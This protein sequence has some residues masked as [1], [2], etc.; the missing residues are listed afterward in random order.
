[1]LHSYLCR[2]FVNGSFAFAQ[3]RICSVFKSFPGYLP[4]HHHLQPQFLLTWT[5]TVGFLTHGSWCSISVQLQC[6]TVR[7]PVKFCCTH[8]LRH[9]FHK[10]VRYT[11][12]GRLGLEVHGS[13]SIFYRVHQPITIRS[14]TVKHH[15]SIPVFC[16]LG[17]RYLVLVPLQVFIPPEKKPSSQCNN[18]APS[19]PAG[20]ERNHKLCVFEGGIVPLGVSHSAVLSLQTCWLCQSRAAAAEE[21]SLFLQDEMRACRGRGGRER[22]ST[23]MQYH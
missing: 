13:I 5:L 21:E 22:G 18:R 6:G 4:L 14:R 12:G 9:G 17:R 7:A 15:T 3:I 11:N 10:P 8:R 20:G 19:P 2:C 23:P 16:V 1:M